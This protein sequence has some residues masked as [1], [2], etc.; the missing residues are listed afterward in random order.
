MTGTC[1]QCGECCSYMGDVFGIIE[2][3]GPY[4]YRIAY[5]ITGVQQIV[6]VDPDKY[7]I[8]SQ[9]TILDKRPMACPFLREKGSGYAICTVHTT[10]PDLC[11]MYLCSRCLV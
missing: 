7:E 4:E 6:R 11:Q 2:D 10:R 1:G 5:L 3:I 9:N 8:F